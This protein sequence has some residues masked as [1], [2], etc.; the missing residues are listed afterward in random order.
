MLI[1]IICDFGYHSNTTLVKVKSCTKSE[2]QQFFCDSNTTLVKVKSQA[3]QLPYK[4]GNN[5][6]T[7][8][9]KVKYKPYK[10]LLQIV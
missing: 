9:V 7:T 4:T 6:N 8:L 10:H 1:N 2:P 5:S 3:P